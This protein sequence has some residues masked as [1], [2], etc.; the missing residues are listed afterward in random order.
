VKL[1]DPKCITI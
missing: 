1:K